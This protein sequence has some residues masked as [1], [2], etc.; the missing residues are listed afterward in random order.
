[1]TTPCFD[2]AE[3]PHLVAAACLEPSI[4]RA[5]NL[6]TIRSLAADAHRSGVGLLVL[7]ECAVQGYPLG[8]DVFPLDEHERLLREAEPVP[9]PTTRVLQEMARQFE[10][11]LVV[12]LTEVPAGNEAAGR[13]YNSVVH[14]AAH[15]ILGHYRKVHL[16][17]IERCLWSPGH[18]WVVSES[19]LGKLGFLICYDILF[20][21]AARCLALAGAQALIHCTASPLDVTDEGTRREGHD[22]VTRIRALENQVYLISA[23]FVGGDDPPFFGHSRIVSP[24]GDVLA[25]T[26]GVGIAIAE[27]ALSEGVL[28]ARARSWFGQ[29]FLNDRQPATYDQLNRMP[30]LDA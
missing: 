14:V 11:E 8:E 24:R 25:E 12:G 7:P 30:R 21:E 23:N 15:G 16:G 17:G 26:A 10:L 4:D 9:G 6:D 5:T 1:M 19:A 28:E 20:P 27:V 13:L 22:L 2:H 18:E 3:R 29:V